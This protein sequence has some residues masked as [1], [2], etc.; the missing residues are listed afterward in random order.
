MCVVLLKKI[1]FLSSVL[2]MSLIFVA[3]TKAVSLGASPGVMDVGEIS[4]GKQYAVDFYLV[5]NS[6]N[7]LVTDLSFLE[8]R[9]TMFEKNQTGRYTFIPDEASEEDMGEW[10]SFLRNKV[11]VSNK[12]SFPVRFPD[13]TT[14]NANERVTIILDVPQDAEP[15]YHTFEVV[16]S[17]DFKPAGSGTGVSMIGVTRPFFVFKIPGVARREGV[18]DGM[19]GSRMGNRAVVDVLFRNTGTVTVSARVSNLNVYDETGN[20]VGSYNG[21]YIMVPPK[22][23]GIVKVIWPDRDEEKQKIIK[24]E[25]TVDY[26]TGEVT[27]EAMIT[28]PKGGVTAKAAVKAEEFPW[29]IIILII[30]IVMLYMYWRRR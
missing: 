17:P 30:G 3:Q 6:Y 21:G 15:G 8:S 5:T 13:G 19:A 20:Y 7:D 9:R 28:I 16:L 29:W 23:T 10:L 25:A 11:V 22:S 2:L 14:V 26:L 4:A 27:K 12:K 24:V 18:V 1:L